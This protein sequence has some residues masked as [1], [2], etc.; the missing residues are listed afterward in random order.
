MT[1]QGQYR[2]R[3]SFGK[4]QEYIA[5]AKLLEDGFDVYMP[6]VDDQQIDCVI[7][8]GNHD[9]LDVQIKAR[10]KNCKPQDAGR[11]SAMSIPCPREK[12]FFLFYSEY[13]KI[14]WIFPSQQL[15]EAASQNRSGKEKGKYSINLTGF[16][17]GAVYASEKFCQYQD[18]FNLL[19][20][21]YSVGS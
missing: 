3:A 21:L 17:G 1:T 11:F 20:T 8:R 6:L 10:S 2:D 14:Y 15:V 7:R 9:Y 4:R 19:R 13:I 5:I 18:N 16:R 12:Y